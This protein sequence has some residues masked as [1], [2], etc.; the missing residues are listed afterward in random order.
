MKW[1][2]EKTD[3]RHTFQ[4]SCLLLVVGIKRSSSFSAKLFRIIFLS[5][6]QLAAKMIELESKIRAYRFVAYS[7]HSALIIFSCHLVNFSGGHIFGG[8]SAVGVCHT[9]NG[10]QLHP[11]CSASNAQWN[12]LLQGMGENTKSVWI[13]LNLFGVKRFFSLWNLSRKCFFRRIFFRDP[14]KTFGRK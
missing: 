3:Q 9:A 11:P 12:Q 5:Q 13:L 6:Q 4:R 8:R 14:P 2:V 7:V 1:I 10:L